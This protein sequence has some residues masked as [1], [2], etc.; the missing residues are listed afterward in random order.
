MSKNIL[1]A[2]TGSISC[3]KACDLISQLVK[4]NYTVR[5]IASKSALK[6]IG[7]AT[8]EGFT[9]HKVYTDS[10]EP[11]DMMSHI[12]LARWADIFVICPASAHTINNLAYGTLGGLIGE[13]YLANDF[14]KPVVIAP[15]M[16]SRM[17]AH[18]A[19]QRALR[20]LSQDGAIVL[21]TESGP[22]A[23]GEAGYGR[24]LPTSQILT[25]I[26]SILEV[27]FKEHSV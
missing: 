5:T 16:N 19:T 7:E 9:S 1:F 17:L 18:P 15:S 14:L 22:L 3:Y 25:R 11:G 4:S 23:C 27:Q 2:L 8:L 13:L 12:D 10:F 21:E 26:Q 24:L 6:F 20:T